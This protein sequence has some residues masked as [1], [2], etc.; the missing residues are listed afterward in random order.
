M[1]AIRPDLVDLASV[2]ASLREEV[3]A[4]SAADGADRLERFASSVVQQIQDAVQ[5]AKQ[6]NESGISELPPQ[7][8]K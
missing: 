5:R 3:N 6:C 1:L 4:A 2:E 8:A 7:H